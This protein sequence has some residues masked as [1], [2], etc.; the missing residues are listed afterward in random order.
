MALI[1][2]AEIDQQRQVVLVHR[3]DQVETGKIAR[4]DLAGPNRAQIDT[5]PDRRGLG[6]LIR[7]I[8]DVVG[9]GAG[10]VYLHVQ[11]RRLA[12]QQMAKHPLRRRRAADIAHADKQ[13][14]CFHYNFMHLS[15]SALT[16]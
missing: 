13:Y 9:M 6:A 10:G 15:R 4:A 3:Q 11:V 8:A 5:A 12:P 7:L 2:R 14:R 16:R 1:R